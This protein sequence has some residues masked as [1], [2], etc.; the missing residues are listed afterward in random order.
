IDRLAAGKPSSDNS[1]IAVGF[2]D[3]PGRAAEPEPQKIAPPREEI[4]VV[5]DLDSRSRDQN[6]W[7]DSST[8]WTLVQMFH[9]LD[10]L[11]DNKD[12][13]LNDWPGKCG[14]IQSVG[15]RETSSG[16]DTW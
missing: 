6:I 5:L 2:C 3:V 9:G 7:A 12:P 14:A 16:R 1:P 4:A 13:L 10:S 8:G 11:D 15:R